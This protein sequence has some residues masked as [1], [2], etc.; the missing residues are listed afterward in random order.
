MTAPVL[1]EELMFID[2]MGS[3]LT[4]AVYELVILGMFLT[5][6]MLLFLNL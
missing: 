6:F 3:N 1:L 4:I 5:L 2:C